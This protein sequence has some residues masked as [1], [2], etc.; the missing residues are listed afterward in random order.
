MFLH[1][2]EKTNSQDNASRVSAQNREGR[3]GAVPLYET[4]LR[5]VSPR[6]EHWFNPFDAPVRL[7]LSGEGISGCITV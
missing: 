1:E 2:M 5:P 4:P 6:L 7:P 3:L